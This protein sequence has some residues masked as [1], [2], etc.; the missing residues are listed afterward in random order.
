MRDER[1]DRKRAD[2]ALRQFKAVRQRER[3]NM[4]NRTKVERIARQIGLRELAAVAG[5]ES[6]YYTLLERYRTEGR[7]DDERTDG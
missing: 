2:T 4:L 6:R 5:D 3:A 1:H 7:S